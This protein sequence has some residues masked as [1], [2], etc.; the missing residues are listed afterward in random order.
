MRS[1]QYSRLAG[2]FRTTADN[3][4]IVSCQ[5]IRWYFRQRLRSGDST[6]RWPRCRFLSRGGS[7]RALLVGIFE[8]LSQR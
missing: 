1:N 6:C 7:A 8:Q 3:D 4:N 2:I 5:N